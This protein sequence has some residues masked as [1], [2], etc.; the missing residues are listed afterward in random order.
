M[1]KFEEVLD[2]KKKQHHSQYMSDYARGKIDGL[3]QAVKMAGNCDKCKFSKIIGSHL[4]CPFMLHPI[5]ADG[6]CY[7]YEERG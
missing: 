2:K 4:R 7:I 3:T 5:K 1:T 6:Y